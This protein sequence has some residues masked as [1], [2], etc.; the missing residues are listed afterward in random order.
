VGLRLS[1]VAADAL[2]DP[3]TFTE[4]G[5]FLRANGLY[6]F[7]INGFPY[8]P[9]HGTRVKED[10]Y[11]PDWQDEERL[12]YTNVLARMATL[13]IR[14]AAHLVRLRE[15]TGHT[16]ALAL[17]AEPC[18]FLETLDETIGFFE[19]HLFA[20]QAVKQLTAE[21]GLQGDTAEEALRHHLGVCLDL[22]HAAVEFEDPHAIAARTDNAGIRIQT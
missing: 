20:A 4:L 21:T 5:E 9:F 16:I 6:V 11:L 15:K 19:S 10:V 8:G 1:A 22:C 17:E 7:T 13:M 3:A 14:H 2:R 18:C 12:R